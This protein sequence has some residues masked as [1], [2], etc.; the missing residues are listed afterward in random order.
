MRLVKRVSKECIKKDRTGK[1]GLYFNLRRKDFLKSLKSRHSGECDGGGGGDMM[2]MVG[3]VVAVIVLF[4]AY[5]LDKKSW[6][7]FYSR[8]KFCPPGWLVGWLY[9]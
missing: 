9:L 6:K 7:L 2:T 8:V 1:V 5:K 3:I 4:L